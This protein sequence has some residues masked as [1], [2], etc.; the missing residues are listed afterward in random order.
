MRTGR[1]W[2]W[3]ISRVFLLAFVLP[4]ARSG[5][6]EAASR[7]TIALV[8]GESTYLGAT[9]LAACT[10]S[11]R[12]V[13]ASLRHDG[14]AVTLLLDASSG[15]ISAALGDFASRLG[16]PAGSAAI[17]YACGYATSDGGRNFLLPVETVL[18][19]GGDAVTEGILA[20]SLTALPERAGSATSL[21]VLDTTPWPAGNAVRPIWDALRTEASA[22]GHAIVAATEEPGNATT[23]TP[24]GEM[25][26]KAL[27]ASAGDGN[28]IATTLSRSFA[29]QPGVTLVVRTTQGQVPLLAPP[30]P[31]PPAA[32]AAPGAPGRPAPGPRG[33][34]PLWRNAR[35]CRPHCAASATMTG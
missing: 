20:R 33:R 14:I 24:V 30:P 27:A 3:Q 32:P 13:A 21:V 23:A 1:R 35:R 31:P 22:A 10:F 15:A 7:P 25:L 8:L 11:A 6:T 17:L 29:G 34:R 4:L 5:S 12:A 28:A 26:A 18:Q 19:R 16:S 2:R 9:P